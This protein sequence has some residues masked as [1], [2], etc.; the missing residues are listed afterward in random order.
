M[1]PNGETKNEKRE[2]KTNSHPS[3]KI[4]FAG[5]VKTLTMQLPIESNS[6]PKYGRPSQNL[7][8]IYNNSFR[9][10]YR[11]VVGVHSSRVGRG[12]KC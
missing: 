11:P 5:H 10:P 7:F 12:I 8:T 4:S 3:L 9:L 6:N 2:K 1:R